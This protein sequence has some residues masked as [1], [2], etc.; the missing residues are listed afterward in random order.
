MFQNLVI[1]FVAVFDFLSEKI[2]SS[3]TH[4]Q[5]S[6]SLVVIFLASI[7]FI[8][9]NKNFYLPDF[10]SHFLPKNIFRSIEV[11][12][13]FLLV[14]EILEMILILSRSVSD[15]MAKQFEILSLILLR[16]SFKEFASF[17]INLDWT[18]IQPILHI[19]SDAFGALF[20]FICV[21]IFLKIQ[22]HYAITRTM[23]EQANYMNIKKILALI[24]LF[25]FVFVG[26]E[27]LYQYLFEGEK[28]NFFHNF[29]NI[30]IFTDILLVLISMRYSHS[31][32]VL[33]RNSG[34]ALTTV[35]IRLALSAPIYINGII[36]ISAVI[37]AIILTIVYNKHGIYTLQKTDKMLENNTI[38]L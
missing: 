30:L 27:N 25:T 4:R 20:I 11:V 6:S 13:T 15:A 28:V 8:W 35:M 26:I 23:Q 17:E 1:K 3:T 37:F 32:F 9:L 16:Q 24:M 33:F 14:V 22:R 21:T 19:A 34:Y 31:Y 10:I 29:Y 38:N 5:I 36:G 12:F 2:E 18:H 7:I